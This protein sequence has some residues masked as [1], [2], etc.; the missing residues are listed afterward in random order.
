[1]WTAAAARGGEGRRGAARG[2]A[3]A[4]LAVNPWRQQSTRRSSIQRSTPPRSPI[5]TQSVPLSSTRHSP[6]PAPLAA[7]AAAAAVGATAL[8]AGRRQPAEGSATAPSPAAPPPRRSTRPIG[9]WRRHES[10]TER[11]AHA[12]ERDASSSSSPVCEPCARPTTAASSWPGGAAATAAAVAV[13]QAMRGI[14]RGSALLFATCRG[15]LTRQQ[16]ND[17]S[18]RVKFRNR[19]ARATHYPTRRRCATGKCPQR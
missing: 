11:A 2:G 13:G 10:C 18:K 8:L 7:A 17:A 4:W 6:A 1:M 16:H 19:V 15:V 14:S 5:R 3:C 12:A 9:C